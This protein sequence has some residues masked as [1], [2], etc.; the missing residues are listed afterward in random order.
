MSTPAP[1]LCF[2]CNHE[3]VVQGRHNFQ[4]SCRRCGEY[5]MTDILSV[6]PPR[7]RTD[8][9]ILSGVLRNASAEGRRL[10]LTTMTVDDL[11]K[12][13][14]VPADPLASIDDILE[15][16]FHRT[17]EFGSLVGLDPEVDYPLIYAR[18]SNEFD[19]L[20][21][22]AVKLEYIW[23]IAGN[24]C[25]L[26]LKG[27]EKIGELRKLGPTNNKVAFMAMPFGDS[28]L[29]DVYKNHIQPAMGQ[30]GFQIRR[31]T[32][33]QGAGLIDDQIRVGIR[34]SRFLVAELTKENRGVY[35]EAGFAEGLGKKV[36]YL[37]R[38]EAEA[39]LETHFDTSHLTTVM[40]QE[41]KL[42]DAMVRLKATVRATFP[43]EAKPTDDA[44]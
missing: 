34:N 17:K 26:T 16:V 12:N 40:W 24:Q 6:S 27:W 29:D 13:A 10:L 30:T 7:N 44:K 21:G 33:G 31:V 18:S 20:L 43:A 38:V 1:F 39:K 5:E 36:I 2:V 42:D 23:T 35:W 8:A 25:V 28:F 19:K 32:E 22:A 15:I 3:A 14:P 37:C 9:Y 11:I 41:S 4:V